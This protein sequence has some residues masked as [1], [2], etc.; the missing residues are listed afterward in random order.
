M[1][2]HPCNSNIREAE[3][4]G[5]QVWAKQRPCF[6]KILK[7]IQLTSPR[8]VCYWKS[9]IDISSLKTLKLDTFESM[10][11][12]LAISV[13]DQQQKTMLISCIYILKKLM[14]V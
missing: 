9:E 2:V 11:S 13:Q 8:W 3:A 1:L 5:L 7:G 6:D 4:E 12:L 14:L 10:I